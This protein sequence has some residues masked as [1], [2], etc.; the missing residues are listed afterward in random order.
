MMWAFLQSIYQEVRRPGKLKAL[1]C[2]HFPLFFSLFSFWSH[3]E[4]IDFKMQN[5]HEGFAEMRG[6]GGR[7]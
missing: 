7:N 1:T 3:W 4:N 2:G 5:T 6:E